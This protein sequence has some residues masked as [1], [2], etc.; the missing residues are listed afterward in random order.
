MKILEDYF[1]VKDQEWESLCIRCG[2]CC[3][4][5]DDP[6][7]HLKGSGPGHYYCDIY[8]RRLG[9]RTTVGGEKFECVPV[10]EILH[11]WWPGSHL[12]AYKKKMGKKK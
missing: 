6:C 5:Y 3:G 4:A 10:R 12:C 11:T 8:E 1:S 7:V 2:A 9:E